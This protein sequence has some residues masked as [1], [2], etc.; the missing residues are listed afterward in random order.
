MCYFHAI[1]LLCYLLVQELSGAMISQWRKDA[2]RTTLKS[3]KKKV[4]DTDKANKAKLVDQV[5]PK[6]TT[7]LC[8]IDYTYRL[9]K[10]QK[11]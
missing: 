3:L 4:D 2:M 8:D 1:Y 9:Q 5:P 6:C 10:K 7:D 11:R